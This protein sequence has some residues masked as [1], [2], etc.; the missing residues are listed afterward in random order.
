MDEIGQEDTRPE[1]AHSD[2]GSEEG[3]F[4][5]VT[6]EDAQMASQSWEQQQQVQ[7]AVEEELDLYGDGDGA[8]GESLEDEEKVRRRLPHP[9]GFARLRCG[10]AHWPWVPR[11]LACAYKP[12]PLLPILLLVDTCSAVYV[13]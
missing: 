8:A 1:S 2:D 6:Q 10:S 12:S 7:A 9:V 11:E 3:G 4:V 5:E 13:G